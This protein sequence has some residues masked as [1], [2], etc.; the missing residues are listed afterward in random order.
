M[1]SCCDWL[2]PWLDLPDDQREAIEMHHLQ[3][4]P[5]AQV[6]DAMGRSKPS[7]AGLIFRGVT[8]VRKRL[9]A[10]DGDDHEIT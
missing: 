4:M 10:T 8:A 2:R 3:G 9:E 5:L 6:A 1:S 7:V